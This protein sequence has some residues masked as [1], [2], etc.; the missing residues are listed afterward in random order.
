MYRLAALVA[1][2][3][4]LATPTAAAPV[5]DT[6]PPTNMS[7]FTVLPPGESG[8]FSADA[9]AQYEADGN[10]S[11][12]GPHVDD[13]REMYWSFQRKPADFQPAT[14]TPVEPQMGV[15]IYRDKWGVP[16]VYGDNGYDVW[17]GAGYAAATDRL[18]EID[19][20]RRSAEGTL[21][22]LAGP[23]DVPSDV[24]ERTL[25]YTKAEYDA[26]LQRLSPAGQAAI[27]GYAAGVEARIKETQANP[28]LLPAEYQVL[29]TTPADWTVED[30]I[31][32]GVY[33][34]RFV[35][36]QGG[37]EM[38]NVTSLQELEKKYDKARGRKAFQ[39]LFPDDNPRA[40]TTITGKHFYNAP[41]SDR[42]A[43]ARERNFLKAAAYAEKLPLDLA[44]GVGT[45]NSAAPALN[46]RLHGGSFAY[47]VT[48]KHTA[49]GNAMLSSNP[50]L[51]YS[52]PSLLFELEVHGGGYDARGVGVPG[53]PT[54]GI[55]HS[56]H[57]AWGLTTGYSKTIDSFIE[58][59]RPNPTNGGPPQYLHN[60]AWHD[61][62]CR[63]ET[64]HYRE[65]P[66]G[67]PT[68]PPT[69]SKDY[70]VCRTVHGPIVATSANGRLARSVDY[71]MWKREVDTV[72]GILMWDRAKSLTDV[73]AGVRKVTWNENIVAA[74]D[75]GNIGY[76]H[77]GLYFRRPAGIDQRF[78]L[79]GRG[80]NDPHGFLPFGNMPHVVDP[81]SG[82][83]ANWNTKPAHGWVDGDLSGS[84]TRPGGR[85]NR[86]AVLKRQLASSRNLRS[87]DLMRIDTATGEADMR[88]PSYLP[89]ILSLRKLVRLNG[90]EQ[91]ALKLL[92]GWDGRAYAPGA[93]GGSSPLGTDA[94]D[95]TDGPAATLFL[96][97]RDRIKNSLFR[98]L[99]S[100]IRARLDTLGPEAHRYDVT[101]L[102]NL[103][104]R[105]VR[106]GWAG[107][108]SPTAVVGKRRPTAVLRRA[109]DAA[110]AA[111]TKQYGAN[112]ST[113]RRHHAISHLDSLTGIVGPSVTMPFEDR[114]S[115]V[116]EVAFTRRRR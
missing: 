49:N 7:A 83:V 65:A 2:L 10:P 50:Q 72:E 105:V 31:A 28:S 37:M 78:P 46:L 114:G 64:V 59:T 20:V 35:A 19:A 75:H 88:A 21:A 79:D 92:A 85:A 18:F 40:V 11:D 108:P 100:S 38:D 93:A 81:P 26:M 54:V 4:L 13:Q 14:G 3:T 76:W 45:G 71:A 30:T 67:V 115:W 101:P 90:K 15:R 58:T 43:K 82:Y 5:A 102:D 57:V 84:N 68:G 106:P 80:K 33:I 113:W 61:E 112:P 70:Q 95:V 32:S 41:S 34:T 73:A 16:L 99:P 12:F 6:P 110:I 42:S 103:A 22:E 62:S 1:T 87:A 39:Q 29:S 9:Q 69:S 51:D 36:S 53:I 27:K 60:G 24:E 109:L 104:L 91:R 86:V 89:V 77:P 66:G 116:Q 23:S 56:A 107:L 111:M 55:G 44:T 98:T 17:F 97:V 96:A 48:G 74:D 63:T 94:A 25:T 47:A 52:Y 8:Y